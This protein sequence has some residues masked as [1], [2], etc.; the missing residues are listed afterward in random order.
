MI[1]LGYNPKRGMAKLTY[2]N[3]LKFYVTKF[4]SSKI[5]LS[6]FPLKTYW[7]TLCHH[8]YCLDLQDVFNV[9]HTFTWDL[10]F[11][12]EKFHECVALL[13]CCKY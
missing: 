9:S 3:I 1:S 13:A 11:G 10:R 12:R 2:I 7:S 8:L 4:L 6:F 5:L